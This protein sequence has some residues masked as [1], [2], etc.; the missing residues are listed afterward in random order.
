MITNDAALAADTGI[1]AAE[2]QLDKA[3]IGMLCDIQFES[4]KLAT[5]YRLLQLLS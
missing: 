2:L 4:M 5:H 1:G 3:I